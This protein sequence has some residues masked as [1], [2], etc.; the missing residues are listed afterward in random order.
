MNISSVYWIQSQFLKHTQYVLTSIKN[1]NAVLPGLIMFDEWRKS[2]RDRQHSNRIHPASMG[3]RLRS[4]SV[5]PREFQRL[6]SMMYIKLGY[7]GFSCVSQ[8][9]IN[10]FILSHF[11]TTT[12]NGVSS[13]TSTAWL[14]GFNPSESYLNRLNQSSH[15]WLNHNKLSYP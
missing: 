7:I 4:P 10:I 13:S 9:F 3:W 15:L 14:G 6:G 12:K 5:K 1:K 8:C 11:C 2:H